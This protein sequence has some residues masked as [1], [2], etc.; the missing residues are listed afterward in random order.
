M[1]RLTF[2]GAAERYAKY[3]LIPGMAAGAVI[4]FYLALASLGVRM[5]NTPLKGMLIVGFVEEYAKFW[6]AN[7]LGWGW[8]GLWGVIVFQAVE[9]VMYAQSYY[10]FNLAVFTLK[11]TAFAMHAMWYLVWLFWPG[12]LRLLGFIQTAVLH[13]LWNYTLYESEYW[14][15]FAV[16]MVTAAQAYMAI[17]GW[18]AAASYRALRGAAFTGAVWR[19]L[20]R[21]LARYVEEEI[22]GGCGE[23]R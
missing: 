14:A 1:A 6:I 17:K 16:F 11:N 18:T 20:A 23:D 2:G 4:T 19:W 22:K 21:R 12:R 15:T 8:T 13:A 9:A 3:V 5:Y 10:M 7:A